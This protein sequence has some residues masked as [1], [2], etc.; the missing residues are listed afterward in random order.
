MGT[1]LHQFKAD[2]PSC[3]Y[4]FKSGKVAE[5]FSYMYRTKDPKEIEELNTEIAAG[6]G[7]IFIPEDGPTIDS[8]DL[9][10]M[11]V[12]R[13]KFFAEFEASKARAENIGESTS[14][15]NRVV[16]AN[17]RNTAA[18]AGPSISGAARII[19]PGTLAK[20]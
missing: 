19:T 13:K 9:D 7:S 12:L 11:N 17:T 20:K 4:V 16:P 5:F 3:R 1:I 15:Q 2:L 8:E 10:P 14:T 18:V 6:I